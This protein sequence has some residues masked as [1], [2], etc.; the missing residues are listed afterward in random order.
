VVAPSGRRT[1]KEAN[2]KKLKRGK[3]GLQ[4]RVLI[5]NLSDFESIEP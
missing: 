5:M 4:N 3:L 2:F 1:G